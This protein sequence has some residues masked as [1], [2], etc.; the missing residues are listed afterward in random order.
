MNHFRFNQALSTVTAAATVNGME[1]IASCI[2]AYERTGESRLE[3]LQ[4]ALADLETWRADIEAAIT[5]T[6][7]DIADEYHNNREPVSRSM[8]ELIQARL[9]VTATRTLNC[10]A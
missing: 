8:Q 3:C 5:A 1:A 6:T 9:G 4:D 7:K 2:K 10:E